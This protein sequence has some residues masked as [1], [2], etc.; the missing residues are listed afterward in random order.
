MQILKSKKIVDCTSREIIE[1]LS[2][3]Y[4]LIGLRPQHFPTQSEDVL[5][6]T[7]IKKHFGHKSIDELYLAF[8]LAITGE[9]DVEDIKVYD[10]FTLEYLMRIMNS[11]KRWLMIKA[12]E[13]NE[14]MK[15]QMKELPPLTE[16]EKIDEIIEWK[17]KQTVH[18]K[19]LPMYLFDWMNQY[20]YMNMTD[21]DKILLY[22]RATKLREF[23]LRNEAET[24][25]G[26]KTPYR[27][28]MRMKESNFENITPDEENKIE[29]IFRK[30]SIFE[31]LKK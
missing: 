16:Q 14:M 21:K 6:L 29:S 27:N 18:Y 12:K 26:D 11:Y 15:P 23:D 13:R 28:F 19:L 17:S 2:I 24:F 4:M 8:E 5:I 22:A 3:I 20:G 30:I 7:F 1:K 31:F 10:Q 25:G 9:L